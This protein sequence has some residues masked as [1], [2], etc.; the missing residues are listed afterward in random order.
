[1]LKFHLHLKWGFVK[2]SE[3]ISGNNPDKN[4]SKKVQ[5]NVHVALSKYWSEVK[6][7]QIFSGAHK[8]LFGHLELMQ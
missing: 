6:F 5:E 8:Y 7:K 1:M 4:C 3:I 2:P